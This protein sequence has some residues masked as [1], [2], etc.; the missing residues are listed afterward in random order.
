MKFNK[1]NVPESWQHYWTR[2]PEGHTILEALISWVSQVDNMVDTLNLSTD[3]VT[4]M[5]LQI[6][7]LFTQELP[8][9]VTTIL[10]DWA[11]D[12]TLDSFIDSGVIGN[13][14]SEIARRVR[15][16]D[17]EI[18]TMAMLS[19]SIKEALTGGA[20]AVVES[21]SVSSANLVE[22]AVTPTKTDFFDYVF[23]NLV[24]LSQ[25]I[26]EYKDPLEVTSATFGNGTAQFEFVGINE[27]WIK[28]TGLEVGKQYGLFLNNNGGWTSFRIYDK[29]KTIIE[30]TLGNFQTRQKYYAWFTP[31]QSE[32]YVWLTNIGGSVTPTIDYFKLFQ[33]DNIP[34]ITPYY[35]EATNELNESPKLKTELLGSGYVGIKGNAI[36]DSITEENN[37]YVK[38]ISQ[39]LGIRYRNHGKSGELVGGI[40][41]RLDTLPVDADFNTLFSGTNNFNASEPLGQ[42][43]DT[44]AS[45]SFYGRYRG[46]IEALLTRYPNKPLILITPLQRAYNVD[47]GNIKTM[48]N[49]NGWKLSQYVAVIKELALEYGLPVIDLYSMSG[50]S[51]YNINN[52]TYD[53]LHPNE[54]GHRKI[55]TIIASEIKKHIPSY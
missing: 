18:I 30:S 10:N 55:A 22:K 3:Q 54:T 19:Q 11:K 38:L 1:L 21:D 46:V 23:D 32:K 36:G 43:T 45:G 33:I 20:V 44:I 37:G 52:Y 51:P 28:L 4:N 12:G 5:Q 14:K 2:Y 41:N 8:N 25:D 16:G 40:L 34:D 50:L 35:N 48:T 17:P 24:Y 26:V 49:N 29:T 42:K 7:E 9:K 6:N 31:D 15:L 27:V 47:D 13:L 39:Q 53:G